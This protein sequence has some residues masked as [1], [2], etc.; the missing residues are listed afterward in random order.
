VAFV[1]LFPIAEGGTHINRSYIKFTSKKTVKRTYE[2]IVS[3]H[4]FLQKFKIYKNCVIFYD[5]KERHFQNN[6]IF[7][8]PEQIIR[9]LIVTTG[10]DFKLYAQN[11]SYD[12]AN[13]KF[14]K[15]VVKANYI[16]FI[17]YHQEKAQPLLDK[18]AELGR[19]LKLVD[20][21]VIPYSE[22]E[23]IWVYQ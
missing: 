14:V 23:K 5:P 18:F 11:D 8:D 4:V 19:E 17:S 9:Y 7:S 3:S 13:E 15:P 2:G 21:Y 22:N 20:E 1:I 6:T 12:Y 16:V 10:S